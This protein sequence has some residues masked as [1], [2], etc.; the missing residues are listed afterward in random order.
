MDKTLFRHFIVGNLIKN[1][2][3]YYK[4]SNKTY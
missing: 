1:Q 4:V 3:T 2:I